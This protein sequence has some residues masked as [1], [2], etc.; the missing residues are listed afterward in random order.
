MAAQPGLKRV[1]S[2][3]PVA[4]SARTMKVV[5]GAVFVGSLY[6]LVRLACLAFANDL[7]ANPVELIE[8]GLG[9]AALVMLLLTLAIS[10]LRWLTGWAWLLRLRRM[11]GLYAFFYAVLHV[12]AYVWLDHW[13]DWQAVWLDI[14]KRPYLT[15]GAAAFVLMIPLAVTSTHAWV[16]R[17]GG[18]N[19]QRLH[20]WVYLIAALAVLHYW[21]HKLAKNNIEDPAIYAVI[22]GLL[23]GARLVHWRNSR[24]R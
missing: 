1:L 21:Y 7:G 23:L 13:F 9:T 17:L 11:L 2:W 24:R 20:R 22:L 15:F 10:P 14:V 18:R 19:W 4:L 3:V 5:K 8:R 12:I 16:R 6:E